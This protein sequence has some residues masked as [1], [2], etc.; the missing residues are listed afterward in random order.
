M[1]RAGG[2][3]PWVFLSRAYATICVADLEGRPA[4]HYGLSRDTTP[5]NHGAVA[6]LD[7]DG[8]A[9]I[10]TA[11]AD[12]LLRAFSAEP[13]TEKC[14][15]CPAADA[16]GSGNRGGKIRW[17]FH[18]PGPIGPPN[19][20]NQN[21]D[22]DFASADLDGD[23]RVELLL[24]GG[25]GRLYALKD[26]DGACAVLWSVD[27]GRRVGSPILADLDGDGTAEIL[28]PT[29]DGRLHC[30]SGSKSRP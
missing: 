20:T 21:S 12:G 22:Q 17:T 27:F 4:W 15:L 14:P 30:L 19:A 10:I 13:A 29:E 26:I 5:R 25:D 24:G 28:V 16:P 6:D 9:E 18:V 7:G 3:P 2:L 23:G 8:Q 1:A 11:Q